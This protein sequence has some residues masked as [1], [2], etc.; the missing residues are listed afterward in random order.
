V[1]PASWGLGFALFLYVED[2]F[3]N[4]QMVVEHSEGQSLRVRVNDQS[5]GVREGHC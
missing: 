2:C 4:G 3:A 1:T 5:R